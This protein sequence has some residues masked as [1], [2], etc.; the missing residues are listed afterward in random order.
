MAGMMLDKARELEGR[1]RIY[2]PSL[3][4][5]DMFRIQQR[6][7]NSRYPR[8]NISSNAIREDPVTGQPLIKHTTLLSNVLRH[9]RN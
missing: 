9:V 5:K 2:T 8:L 1:W 4:I 6:V 7:L 3:F